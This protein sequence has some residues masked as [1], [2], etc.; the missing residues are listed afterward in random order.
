MQN[1]FASNYTT[2]VGATISTGSIAVNGASVDMGTNVGRTAATFLVS[3]GT[4][5]A[6][7]TL[8][9]KL[10]SSP[11]NSTWTDEPALA[12]TS[13]SF[14]LNTISLPQIL[15]ATG[16]DSIYEL[17]VNAPNARYYRCVA[18]AATANVTM[19]IMNITRNQDI[20]VTVVEQT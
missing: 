7:S 17:S 18:T 15:A 2:A 16:A 10:Q 6:T 19:G 9:L 11:D 13:P 20:G 14:S 1:D 4:M 3:V 12:S 5:V 8:D